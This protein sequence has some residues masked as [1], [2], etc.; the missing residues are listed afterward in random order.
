MNTVDQLKRNAKRLAKEKNIPHCQALDM[1]A[2]QMGYRNWSLFHK[3]AMKAMQ[4]K[5][6]GVGV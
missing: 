3:A 1:L 2:L 6:Q 4:E 5:K